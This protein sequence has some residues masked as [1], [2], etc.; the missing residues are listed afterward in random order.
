MAK[1]NNTF[2]GE[3]DRRFIDKKILFGD[4]TKD[5]LKDYLD[6]LPDLSDNAEEITITIKER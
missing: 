1:K 4:I 5:N 6:Q 3:T 2:Q